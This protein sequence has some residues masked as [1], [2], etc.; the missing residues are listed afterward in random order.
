MPRCQPPFKM[1]DP[2]LTL[3]LTYESVLTRK[4][5]EEEEKTLAVLFKWA[6][7]L[8]FASTN[9]GE[10]SGGYQE[11]PCEYSERVLHTENRD[12]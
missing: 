8:M 12:P 9:V 10:K 6:T 5:E 3:E 4:E 2:S 11:N 7:T 1:K